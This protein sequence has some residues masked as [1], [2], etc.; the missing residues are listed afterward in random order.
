MNI[1]IDKVYSDG[2]RNRTSCGDKLISWLKLSDGYRLVLVWIAIWFFPAG[3]GIML[4]DPGYWKTYK[5][6]PTKGEKFRRWLAF[7]TGALPTTSR[8]YSE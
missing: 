3:K 7:R 1:S 4:G 2:I 6:C 8:P 5:K